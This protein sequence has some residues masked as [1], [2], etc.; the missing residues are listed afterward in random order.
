MTLPDR[1]VEILPEEVQVTYPKPWKR[2]AAWTH[3]LR[4]CPSEVPTFLPGVPIN[5]WRKNHGYQ[6]SS[7]IGQRIPPVDKTPLR[8][9]QELSKQLSHAQ[10]LLVRAL[11]LGSEEFQNLPACHGMKPPSKSQ[12]ALSHLNAACEFAE[13]CEWLM[14]ESLCCGSVIDGP[15]G[16]FYLNQL[17]A[18]VQELDSEY[19]GTKLQELKRQLSSQRAENRF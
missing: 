13:T 4:H 18:L 9:A 12:E 8:I 15:Q 16:E 17:E 7:W 1:I 2:G 11:L 14:K 3:L 10:L 6:V 5:P 19:Y